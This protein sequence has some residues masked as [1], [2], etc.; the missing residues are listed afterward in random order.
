MVKVGRPVAGST[1]HGPRPVAGSRTCREQPVA[2]VAHQ[3]WRVSAP[4]AERGGREDLPVR[5]VLGEVDQVLA[6]QHLAVAGV[7]VG[8]VAERVLGVRRQHHDLVRGPRVGAGHRHRDGPDPGVGQL[9]P[10]DA[11]VGEGR[12]EGVVGGQG[13]GGGLGGARA[14][15]R[16][17][18][19]DVAVLDRDRDEA[20]VR[21]GQ[22]AEPLAQQDDGAA[23]DLGLGDGLQVVDRGRPQGEQ[24]HAA[25]Q[26]VAGDRL[27]VALGPGGEPTLERRDGGRGAE[28]VPADGEVVVADQGALA[29]GGCGAAAAVVDE[30]VLVVEVLAGQRRRGVR[31]SGGSRLSADGRGGDYG[32]CGEDSGDG[33]P[34]ACTHACLL[35]SA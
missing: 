8:G 6:Q 7:D 29:G 17:D 1:S 35:R 27:R 32:G 2:V 9:R 22:A 13:G 24:P 11:G 10:V 28:P 16:G 26:V 31:R 30:A 25:L 3:V 5:V 14:Q 33:G 19:Q 4:L 34:S 23:A 15:R 18:P 20:V 12:G 21:G